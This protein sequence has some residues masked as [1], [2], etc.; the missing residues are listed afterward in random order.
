MPEQD[1]EDELEENASER[2]LEACPAC[3]TIMDMTDVMPFSEI[4]CPSCGKALRARKQFNNFTL[5]EQIGEGGMGAVF[6]ALDRNL[7]RHVA[8]KILKKEC[9]ANAEE[10]QKLE[11][12][13][14]MTA[15]I[16]HP[17]VV[18]VFD[19][20]EDRG[21]FYIAMELVEKGSLDHLM[22]IQRRVAEAQ[23]LEVGIQIAQGLEAALETGLIHRDIKPGNILFADPHTAKLV[24]FGLAILM[25]LAS[26]SHGEIWGT[27]YYIAP[28]KLDNTPE[29]FR[30]DIYSLGGTLFHALAGRPPYDAESASMVALKQLKSQPVSLQSFAPDISS[31][32]AY[33]INRMM[34]KDPADRYQSYTELISHLTYAREKLLERTRKPLQPKQRVVLET[35]ETRKVSAFLSLGVLA[36]VL[37]AGLVIFLMRDSIFPKTEE[38]IAQKNVMSASIA[39]EA[40]IN[41]VTLLADGNAGEALTKFNALATGETTPQPQKNWA[42]L[43]SALA[44]IVG[45]DPATAVTELSGLTELYSTDAD[46]QILANFF[47]ETARVISKGAPIQTSIVRLYSRPT[48]AFALLLFGVWNWEA[49]GDPA[50]AAKLLEAFLRLEP[51]ESWILKYHPLAEKYLS[52]WALIQPLEAS[53]P[54]ITTPMAAKALADR[55]NAARPQLQSGKAAEQYLD[56]LAKRAAAKGAGTPP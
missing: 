55:I 17:H 2:V 16:N 4:F 30:S 11:E 13:A 18:K 39:D 29:D 26:P 53:L 32:T 7:N 52:D 24:D 38:A 50:G 41:G 54:S 15:G 33:V 14:R 44:S 5:L 12:E 22:S 6:K 47:V 9:S 43:N 21:Q 56:V 45:G 42:I 8:L 28:E 23:I 20:G 34:A 46:K 49:K 10:R 25:D 31:E 19:F 35:A 27:P 48:D 37:V 3:A 36:A 51:T 40:L 1:T